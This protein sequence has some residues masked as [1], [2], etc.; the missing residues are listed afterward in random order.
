[1]SCGNLYVRRNESHKGN[2]CVIIGVKQEKSGY[3]EN[4]YRACSDMQLLSGIHLVV[5]MDSSRYPLPIHSPS[6][7]YLVYIGDM[8]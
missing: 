1:M 8:L 5:H 2:A 3:E 7:C 4:E 6:S